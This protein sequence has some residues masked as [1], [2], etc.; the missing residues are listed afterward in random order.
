M[1]KSQ[2]VKR[3]RPPVDEKLGVQVSTRLPDGTFKRLEEIA[4]LKE[5]S[6]SFLLRKATEE[7]LDRGGESTL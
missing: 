3:G 4:K 6:I 1:P 7:W 5:R 2:S